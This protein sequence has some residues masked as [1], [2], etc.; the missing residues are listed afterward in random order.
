[1]DFTYTTPPKLV[2]RP[3]NNGQV[4]ENIMKIVLYLGYTETETVKEVE[5]QLHA[6]AMSST[7]CIYNTD[8]ATITTASSPRLATA[9]MD[10]CIA[11]DKRK[12]E[13]FNARYPKLAIVRLGRYIAPAAKK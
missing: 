3:K 4:T 6:F 2:A 11:S 8:F 1:M 10:A 5:R 13:E 12:M 7:H 9:I